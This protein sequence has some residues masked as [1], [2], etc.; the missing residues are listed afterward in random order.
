M[1]RFSFISLHDD[2][3][4]ANIGVGNVVAYHQSNLTPSGMC[5]VLRGTI[6]TINL[7]FSNRFIDA[8]HMRAAQPVNLKP[9]IPPIAQASSAG[10]PLLYE[11]TADGQFVPY[12][13]SPGMPKV[14]STIPLLK[15]N[16]VPLPARPKV[17]NPTVETNVAWDGWPD[18]SF[19]AD[20][21]WDAVESTG[22]LRVHW[23]CRNTGGDRKGSQLA[24]SWEQGKHSTRQCMG[25][26][27]C[28]NDDCHVLV[29]PQTTPQGIAKQVLHACACGAVL[30]HYSCPVRSI[31]WTWKEGIHY[32]N[33][34]FHNHDCLTHLLHLLPNEQAQFKDLISSHLHRSN[35]FL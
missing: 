7:L 23:S 17:D 35:C 13:Q 16:V 27:Q 29:R 21:A 10:V 22:N 32:K 30:S 6:V 4:Y 14:T 5:P 8:V 24:T 2:L 26:I 19:E 9:L 1:V 15:P 31:L 3:S 12:T 18:G 34:G 11:R 20:Y 33:G 28:D 25:I